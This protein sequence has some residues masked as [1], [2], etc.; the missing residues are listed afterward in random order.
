MNLTYRDAGL[1]LDVYEQTIQG[2]VPPLNALPSGCKFNPRCPDVMPICLGN[3]PAR[4]IVGEGHDARCYL[5]GD[6]AD[7][8]RMP[9]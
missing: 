6:L 3:E 9:G 2:M 4:M 8:E 7:P 5:H 1:D